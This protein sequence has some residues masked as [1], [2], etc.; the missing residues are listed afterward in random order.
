MSG[1]YNHYSHGAA[2][3][4]LKAALERFL[5]TPLLQDIESTPAVRD[6]VAHMHEGA[7]GDPSQCPSAPTNG[8]YLRQMAASN[9]VTAITASSFS[10]FYGTDRCTLQQET[11][12]RMVAKMDEI[13]ASKQIT[14]NK[15]K[16][17]HTALNQGKKALLDVINALIRDMAENEKHVRRLRDIG[18]EGY[19]L[20]TD[21]IKD[22][23]LTSGGRLLDD[24]T[25]AY[26]TAKISDLK[27]GGHDDDEAEDAVRGVI[28]VISGDFGQELSITDEAIRNIAAELAIM[29]KIR[30]DYLKFIQSAGLGNEGREK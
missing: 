23:V 6:A 12:N 1:S 28:P 8:W 9:Y 4:D 17:Y 10:G 13:T 19:A 22:T 29:Q 15:M 26:K 20:H 11:V 5:N 16:L 30:A 7:G 3:N 24:I 21:A 27:R 18:P 25:T 14:P 2:G